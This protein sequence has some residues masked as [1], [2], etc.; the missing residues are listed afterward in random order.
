VAIERYIDFRFGLRLR[1]GCA[2][3][4]VGVKSGVGVQ[5]D[6]VVI[7]PF[8]CRWI[9]FGVGG[10][11]RDTIERGVVWEEMGGLRPEKSVGLLFLVD[12]RGSKG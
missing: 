4:R 9:L 5:G 3:S 11:G 10:T 2:G 7:I 12:D 6:W 1:K 8:F